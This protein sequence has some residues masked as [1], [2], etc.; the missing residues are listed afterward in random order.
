MNLT[1]VE[2]DHDFAKTEEQI[3]AY[4]NEIDAFQKSMALSKAA[5]RPDFTFYDGPPFATGLPHYGHLLAGTIKDTV[6]R[7]AHQK[8][9]HVSRRFGWDCHGLPVEYEIDQELKITNRDQVFEMGI[10]AYNDKCRGIV[11]RYTVEWEKTVTRIGRWIDFKKNYRTMDPS[12]MESVWWVFKSLFEKKLVYQGYKVMPFST[13][14]GTPLSNFEA[15]LNYQ[16]VNDPA[17]VIM[18]PIVG[19]ET[20]NN[21]ETVHLLAW[22]TTPW[23]LPS[24]LALCVNNTFDYLKIRD[25]KTNN[26]YY[27]AESRLSQLYPKME[28]AK[29]KPADKANLFEEISRCKGSDLVGLKYIP[30][31]DYFANRETSFRVI[32]D[33]YV[34]DDSGTGIVHQAPAF[35]EDD[36]RVCLHHNIIEKVR[37]Q[38]TI[39]I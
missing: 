15:G 35:G 20:E 18:F 1:S 8:G 3:L 5:N 27:I 26:L 29:F 19:S 36:Y 33:D 2:A 16:D 38:Q 10:K 14:C 28:S 24:N 7:F 12:F 21:G 6:T 13:T 25:K 34:K 17:V 23:T 39:K 4:W 32:C 37:F 11:S 30:L 9:Y 31:F 22:T